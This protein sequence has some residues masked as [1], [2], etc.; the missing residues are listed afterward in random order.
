MTRQ[1]RR[2]LVH[3][4]NGVQGAAIA[5]ELRKEGFEVYG[6]VRNPTKSAAL[7]EDGV[8]VIEADLESPAALRSASDG[9]DAVVLTLPLEWN[10]ETVLRWARN[11]AQAARASGVGLLVMNSGTR[12][13]DHPTDVPAYELRRAVEALLREVGPPTIVLRPPFYMDNLASPW[14]AAGIARDRTLAYPIAQG[15][16][17]SWLASADLGAYVAA[18]LRR[19]DLA[20]QTLNIGGPETLD[21]TELAR[22]L[23][24]ALGIG[25]ASCRE[26][27]SK[28]V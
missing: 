7:Q 13:P 10:P 1:I 21:G 4:V 23:S 2:V 8:A 6:A 26:R 15:L 18:A 19:S 9:M 22:E 11:A 25:R 12:L 28:Q 27:V 5:R 20:G 14:I 24:R 17:A 3:C 16:R